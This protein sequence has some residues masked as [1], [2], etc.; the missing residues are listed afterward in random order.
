LFSVAT[1]KLTSTQ[2]PGFWG[3]SLLSPSY[4]GQVAAVAILYVLAALAGL[5]LDSVS[6][7]AS[8][9]WAPTGI[10]LAAVLLAGPRLWLGIFIGA[11][12]ANVLTGA[13]PLVASGIATGNTLEAVV[14]AYA[15][16]RVAGFHLTL[17]S[18]RDVFALIVLAAVL[19]TMISATIGVATLHFAGLVTPQKLWETWRTWWVGDAIGALLVAP[20]I[21]VWMTGP[22]TSL[23]ARRLA[24]AALLA[25]GLV[26][27]SLIMFVVPG[28]RNGGPFGQAYAFFPLLMWAAIRF[29][30]R[31]AVTATLVVSAI[32]IAGTV[33]LQGPFIRPIL[34]E[35]L[36]ALQTFLGITGA[37]FLVL[38][39][40]ISE[41]E[42]SREQLRQARDIATRANQA[43]A[44][45]LAVMSHELR[46]PLNAIAGYAELLSIGVPGPL[47]PKQDEAVTRIRTNQ[48]HLLA[49][50]DDVLHFAKIEA[51]AT[52]I[53]AQP[54]RVCEALDS[55]E[56]LLRPDL[57]RHELDFVWGGCDPTL[58]VQAD[59]VK[60]RQ[61]MLNVLGNAIKFTPPHGRIELSALRDGESVLI[62]VADT[63]IG[64]P[65]DKI[66]RV[67]EPFF[68]VQ[69][70]PTREFAGVGLGLAISR[71]F[72]R[73][74]GGDV[75]VESAPR[76]GC[77]VT[78]DLAVA[79]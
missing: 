42:R 79:Q 27:A 57:M 16:R 41:R 67:F 58:E 43:K 62:C 1:S 24:E 29:G 64:I 35:S 70:G 21:L 75:R 55:L 54:L 77:L 52:P 59:P 46:T 4:F 48:R 53:A 49:L 23:S 9:V 28:T 20:V 18:L 13:S 45:F 25:L 72:A 40:S 78:I 60:L 69:T 33:S 17:D 5:R 65:A 8:L 63:G 14:G 47:T 66:D 68:Q 38:G 26:V 15:F 7:F 11:L 3:A 6:G 30:Q 31:G 37:T 73:A 2:A 36:L 10:A 76:E 32:A 56:D 34:H 22:R 74:M 71:D 12:V 61:I 19:S 51:G 39:A 44:E 50:I